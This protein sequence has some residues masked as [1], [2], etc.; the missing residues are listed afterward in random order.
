MLGVVGM[1]A[2][3]VFALRGGIT[4]GEKDFSK[5]NLYRRSIFSRDNV[6][7]SQKLQSSYSYLSR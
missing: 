4:I 1:L 5:A 6:S 2:S 7:L 3:F